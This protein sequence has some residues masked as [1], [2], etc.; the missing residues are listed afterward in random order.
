VSHSG[1]ASTA[2]LDPSLIAR[3][4]I[5]PSSI[6]TIACVAAPPSKARAVLCMRPVSPEVMAASS[7]ANRSGRPADSASGSPS[8]DT[9]IA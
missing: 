8:A 2:R 6:S 3:T 1:P 4:N 7:S 5:S 9:T